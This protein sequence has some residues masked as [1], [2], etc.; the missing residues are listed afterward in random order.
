MIPA[1]TIPAAV[2]YFVVY[3]M[4]IHSSD[5]QEKAH[6]ASVGAVIA[7]AIFLNAL[8][9]LREDWL[10]A[11]IWA[12]ALPVAVKSAVAHRRAAAQSPTPKHE[13]VP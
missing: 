9:D 6:L 4:L 8:G 5:Q 2:T 7:A 1:F 12:A 13:E 10:M 3:V 11:L